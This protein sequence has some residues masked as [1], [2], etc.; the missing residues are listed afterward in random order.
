[1][2]ITSEQLIDDRDRVFTDWG[3]TVTLKQVAQSFDPASQQISE[4]E[5][6]LAVTAIVGAQP[7]MNVADAGGQLQSVDLALQIRSEDWT[8][9]AGDATWRALVRGQTYDVVKQIE[10]ADSQVIELH[11]RKVA[12]P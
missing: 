5:T 9:N 6:E 8:A 4:T 2:D 3:E 1:M 12:G 11:C 10:S 7:T